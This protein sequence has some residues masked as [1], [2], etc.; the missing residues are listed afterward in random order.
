MNFDEL[1]NIQEDALQVN[2]TYKIF[3][4]N[5]RLTHSKSA[6]VEHIT[7]VRYI[8]KYLRPGARILDIGAGA[9]EYS[10]HFASKG[11]QVDAVELA[12]QNVRDFRSK[13][14]SNMTITLT[15]GNALDLKAFEPDSYDIVLLMGPLYH[16][17][18]AEER[19]RV[20]E[21]AKRV[22]KKSGIIFFAFIGH[23]MVFLTELM[24]DLHYFRVGDYNHETMRL[25]DFP[26]VFFTVEES[27]NMLEANGITILHAIAQDGASELMSERIDAMDEDEYAQY[28]RYHEM[29]CEKPELLGMSNHVLYIGSK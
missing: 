9:G 22:C 10:L 12:D 20:I 16:L 25:E 21:E 18:K 17:H 7:T 26:F 1:R 19:A 29:I 2:E 27:R 14:Q 6:Q 24:Y 4:E 5:T 15:Q 11:Y 23:D 8:E 13:I 3:H 28:L